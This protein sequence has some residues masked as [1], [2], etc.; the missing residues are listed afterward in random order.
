MSSVR[1]QKDDIY[2]DGVNGT[3][4]DFRN[5]SEVKPKIQLNQRQRSDSNIRQFS[6]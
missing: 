1:S 2:Q 5:S 3:V 6:N 4:L